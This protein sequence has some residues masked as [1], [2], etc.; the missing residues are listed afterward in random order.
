MAEFHQYCEEHFDYPGREIASEGFG[1]GRWYSY[2][3]SDFLSGFVNYP[4]IVEAW[5]LDRYRSAAA[6]KEDLDDFHANFLHPVGQSRRYHTSLRELFHDDVVILA[7]A[8]DADVWWLF[9]FDQDVS[10]SQIACFR[11]T[12]D[13]DDVVESF[14]AYLDSLEWTRQPIDRDGFVGWIGG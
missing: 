9:W 10:D 13:A 12:D 11:T 4:T 3:S 5:L 14:H 7:R 1:P 8:D 6:N 2:V